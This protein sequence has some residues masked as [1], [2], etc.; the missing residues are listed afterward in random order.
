MP[1]HERF[2]RTMVAGA[3]GIDLFLL[4]VDAARGRGR[5]R[6]STSPILR[7]L[8]V[9]RGVV[10]VTKA[11]LVDE[12]TLEV[13]LEEARELV[14]DAEAVAV[15][16]VTGAGLDELRGAI[17]RTAELVR[18]A[19]SGRGR[20][21]RACTSTASFSLR[22]IG[23][24]ATGTL[25]SGTIAAGD[26]LSVEPRGL[27]VRVRSV[28][29]HDRAVE[30]ADAGQR[31][32][33]ALRA[34][35]AAGFAAATCWS[36]REP[37]TLL[38]ARRGAHGA[39]ADRGRRPRHGP[40]RDRRGAGAR[41]PRRRPLRAA[42]PGAAG[43]GRARRPGRSA[44]R[45]TVGGGVVLD[46]AP[47]RHADPE[48]FERLERGE[49]AATVHA[50]VPAA[51]L[52]RLGGD[53]AFDGLG[54]AGEWVFST[55]WLEELRA[56]LEPGSTRPTRSI[57]ASSRPRSRGPGTSSRCWAW[58]AAGRGSIVRAR[59]RRS[60]SARPRP[61]SSSR[62][63]DA[64]APGATK[65]EDRELAR[66]LE[67]AGRLV[68]LGDGYAV[69][70]P[71]YDRAVR[72]VRTE[73][74]AAGGIAL[75]RFRDLAGVGRRDAQLLLERMDADGFTRRAGDARVLRRRAP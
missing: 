39:R 70:R 55:A 57:P 75:A 54:R 9:E 18:A 47:P 5:R 25:W 37:S 46:P 23:T 59:R 16:A 43:G 50:P 30:R 56:E 74:E 4:V 15:S 7:L 13:A 63:L 67:R 26:V 17:A 45:T 27:E 66:F 35:S 10:A 14:P 52:R 21:R 53:E 41:R 68:R 62:R 51:S 34:S 8:G 58:S 42:A 19:T 24:V 3:T 20:A 28:Q 61:K 32:A 11:D 69:G 6:T 33:V 36:R 65:V 48:R 22:G 64:A 29:V 12:E 72:L 60:A 31:V 2:V 71:A 1:G 44:G 40:P 38:P 49:L 73:C